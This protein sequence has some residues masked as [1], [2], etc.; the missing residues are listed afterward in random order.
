LP[1]LHASTVATTFANVTITS[2]PGNHIP[3]GSLNCNGSGCHSTTNVNP[4]GFNIG[5]ANIN[6]PTLTTAGHSTIAAAVGSC[7]TC[8]ET[9][10]YLGMLTSFRDLRRR[11]APYGLRQGS[12]HE[13]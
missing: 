8:H 7:Q 13:R 6:N 5:T 1:E 3:I 2:T 9:A 10:P 4:G 11:F 12:S